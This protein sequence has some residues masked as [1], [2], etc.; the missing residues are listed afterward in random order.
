MLVLG[1]VVS[2]VVFYK[3][4]FIAKK[5]VELISQQIPAYDLLRKLNNSLIEKERFLYEFYAAEQ[6]QNFELG[7]SE[8]NQQAQRVFEELVV[9]FGDIPPLQI[10]QTSLKKL[11]LLADEFGLWPANN[12]ALLVMYDEQRVRKSSN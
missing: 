7:Y 4:D 3:G 11:N 1:I 5:T 2:G 9:R 8:A 6:L 10:T 12:C